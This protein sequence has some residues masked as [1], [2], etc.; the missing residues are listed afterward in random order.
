MTIGVH[1]GKFPT[2]REDASVA[3]AV[4][5]HDIEYPVVN[6]QDG[7]IWDAYAVRAW[8]TLLLID[9]RGRVVARHAGEIAP[10]ALLASLAEFSG[11][12]G[13]TYPVSHPIA[14]HEAVS[15]PEPAAPPDLGVLQGPSRSRPG[16]FAPGSAP[17][18]SGILGHRGAG[19]LA[20]V[21]NSGFGPSDLRFPAGLL[22]TAAALFVA[23]TGNHRVVRLGLDGTM[24]AVYGSGEAGFAD[25]AAG[26]ARFRDP[27]GLALLPDGTLAVADT[28]NHAIRAV[29]LASGNVQT[30]AGT[31]ERG[32][33]RGG[34]PGR[35]TALASPWDVV[36]HDGALWI[37]MAGTH[38]LWRSDLAT[39]DARPAA[40]SGAE[41][42][43]DGP[44]AE[45]AFAQPS[46]IAALGDAL[47]VADAEASAVRR[48]DLGAGRV[49]RLI[50]RGLFAWGHINGVGDTAHLQHPLAIAAGDG[51]LW[52][53]DTYNHAIRRLDPA[54]RRLVTLCGGERGFRDGSLADARFDVP[55]AG[56]AGVDVLW[57]AT[58]NIHAPRRRSI[59]RGVVEAVAIREPG[60]QRPLLTVRRSLDCHVPAI[61][62]SPGPG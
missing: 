29:D 56:A 47:Y 62:W 60:G 53:A 46:G 12:P 8:P 17:H 43:H 32:S 1:R 34:K 48:V 61:P 36:W 21:D 18:A 19:G 33:S 5:R 13:A 26:Q 49:R 9:A 11:L 57:V 59:R 10:P 15:H 25:G 50:G 42:L 39:G 35:E 7:A 55:G 28:G 24:L 31:G 41:G 16:V 54:T 58:T 51:A 6:D 45:A 30:L 40:G 14:P 27:H 38:Q 3:A 52:L 2:E 22:A 4:A 44:L 23:D 37:A 20:G